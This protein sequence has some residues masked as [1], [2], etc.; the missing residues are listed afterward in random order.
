MIIFSKALLTS[1]KEEYKNYITQ[2]LAYPTTRIQIDSTADYF[3][4]IYVSNLTAQMGYLRFYFEDLSLYEVVC[5]SE[6]VREVS[7]QATYWQ[8]ATNPTLVN[9]DVGNTYEIPCQIVDR[10]TRDVLQEFIIYYTRTI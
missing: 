8:I 7:E 3:S 1:A 10:N 4:K 9:M 2:V 6:Y 5:K